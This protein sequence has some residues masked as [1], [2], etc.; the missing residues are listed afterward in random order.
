MAAVTTTG[1][2]GFVASGTTKAAGSSKSFFARLLDSIQDARMRQ[3]ER[4]IAR[5]IE[6]KG[7]RL[8]DDVERQIERSFI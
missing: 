8:T 3:A 4:E 5:F 1:L 2:N 6:V 7:G